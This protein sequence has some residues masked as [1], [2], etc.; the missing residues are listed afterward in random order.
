M[1]TAIHCLLFTLLHSA[2]CIVLYTHRRY[3]LN[4]STASMQWSVSH[5]RNVEV[6]CACDILPPRPMLLMSSGP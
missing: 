6:S 3:R 4:Y 5:K 1:L 2:I